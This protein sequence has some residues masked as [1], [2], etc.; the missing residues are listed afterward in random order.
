M[1]GFRQHPPA[2][3]GRWPAQHPVA[4]GALYLAQVVADAH[5]QKASEE[6]GA[7]STARKTCVGSPSGRRD[8]SVGSPQSG[9]HLCQAALGCPSRPSSQCTP[10]W[11]AAGRRS[12]STA[13]PRPGGPG[14]AG[15]SLSARAASPR[16]RARTA[17]RNAIPAAGLASTLVGRPAGSRTVRR[18]RP[19]RRARCHRA[20]LECFHLEALGG[21][22]RLSQAQPVDGRVPPPLQRRKPAA[23]G[24]PCS[25]ARPPRARARAR[26]RVSRGPSSVST[27]RSTSR[28][29]Q[30]ASPAA[31]CR[32]ASSARSCSFAPGGQAWRSAMTRPGC[33]ACSRARSRSANR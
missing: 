8:P 27:C 19:Q 33:S 4:L 6:L 9:E 31:A 18:R 3:A 12:A 24:R 1:A 32:T 11:R 7:P 13:R 26:A 29:S 20:G 17:R 10:A 28:A 25:R 2:L 21:A 15:C 5:G 22:V 23:Q 14:P 16:S 30:A